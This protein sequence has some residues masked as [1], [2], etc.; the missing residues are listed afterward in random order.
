MIKSVAGKSL[1]YFRSSKFFLGSPNEPLAIPDAVNWEI[2]PSE[3]KPIHQKRK[4]RIKVKPNLVKKQKNVD[5]KEYEAKESAGKDGSQSD[6]DE[7]RDDSEEE[8]ERKST[9]NVSEAEDPDDEM[10]GGTDYASNYFDNGEGYEDGEDD[11]LD[12]GGEY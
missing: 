7:T 6:K 9:D 11:N 3:L 4:S 10:D 2:L 5:W 8:E 12:E 1:I